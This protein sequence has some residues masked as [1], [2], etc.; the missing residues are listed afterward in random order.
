MC[1]IHKVT[2][3]ALFSISGPRSCTLSSY[4]IK[5]LQFSLLMVRIHISRG[6]IQ[7][8]PHPNASFCFAFLYP[9][10][11]EQRP[12]MME[13]SL[14]SPLP[15]KSQPAFAGHHVLIRTWKNHRYWVSTNRWAKSIVHS[16]NLSIKNL[17]SLHISFSYLWDSPGLHLSPSLISALYAAAGLYT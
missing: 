8:H 2:L 13:S 9:C 1:L 5:A 10:K 16:G 4:Q 12:E 3:N 17:I 7:L 14:T 15:L 6:R 11:H